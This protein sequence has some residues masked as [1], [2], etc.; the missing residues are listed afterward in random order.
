M[1]GGNGGFFVFNVRVKTI[2]HAIKAVE[3]APDNFRLAR[4]VGST[5]PFQ[6]KVTQHS[7]RRTKH[8]QT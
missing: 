8:E 1:F 5:K 2:R 7:S 3:S 4:A 6:Q